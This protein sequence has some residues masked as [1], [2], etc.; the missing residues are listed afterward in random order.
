VPVVEG[1]DPTAMALGTS[2]HRSVDEA[3]W[4]IGISSH[5][6]AYSSEVPI[7]TIERVPASRNVADKCAQGC[8][9]KIPLDEVTHFGEDCT[10]KHK[11]PAFPSQLF[12]H[13]VV[14]TIASVERGEQ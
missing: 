10:W 4:Q 14:V 13:L 8:L 9:S 6:F 1:G 7:P 11:H 5:E 12:Q 3:E 2:D